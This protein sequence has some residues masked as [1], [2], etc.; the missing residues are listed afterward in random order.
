MPDS[1]TKDEHTANNTQARQNTIVLDS[2][3]Y[4]RISQSLLKL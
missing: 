4:F 3:A 2:N 1:P